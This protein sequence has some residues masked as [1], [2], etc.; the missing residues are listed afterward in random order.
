MSS[1]WQKRDSEVNV[2]K[3][4]IAIDHLMKKGLGLVPA[5]KVSSL[6]TSPRKMWKE[7]KTQTF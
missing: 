7:S 6:S 5:S 4:N 1:W 2:Y 3:M